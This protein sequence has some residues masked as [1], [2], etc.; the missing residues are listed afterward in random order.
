[1]R[2]QVFRKAILL[3]VV[4]TSLL[5]AAQTK[6]ELSAVIGRPFL[7]D[8]PVPNTNFFD[9]TIHFGQPVSIEVSY[10][11]KLL[12][13]DGLLA[14]TFEVPVLFTPHLKMN[15]GINTI[16]ESYSAFFVTPSLRLNLFAATHVSP[17]VSFGGGIAHFSESDKL[18][19]GGP[20]PG[21][22][23]TTTGVYQIGGGLDVRILAR[24]S[25]RGEVRDYN[26]GIPQLNVDYGQTRQRNLF[27]GGGLIF[28]F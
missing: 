14:L 2:F 9:N 21:A 4:L 11:R 1:M 6:S 3:S 19:F 17:W 27:V 20:N 23:G 18:L 7:V 28:H 26:S 10:G 24:L 12:G 15:Y 25:L 8:R 22:T 5:A 13:G 16:P